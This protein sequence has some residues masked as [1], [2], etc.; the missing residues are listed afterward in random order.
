MQS[1][2]NKIEK[3]TKETFYGE[4]PA[5]NVEIFIDTI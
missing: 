5:E 1:T 4:K 2:R 3:I